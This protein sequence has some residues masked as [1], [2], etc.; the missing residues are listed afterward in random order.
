M[1][2]TYCMPPGSVG[3]VDLAVR[4]LDRAR[5]IFATRIEWHDGD[6]HDARFP[7]RLARGDYVVTFRAHATWSN[8]EQIDPTFSPEKRSLGIAVATIGFDAA[9]TRSEADGA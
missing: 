4:P 8:P 6:W 9:S 3:A 7:V 1:R 5:T 2:L